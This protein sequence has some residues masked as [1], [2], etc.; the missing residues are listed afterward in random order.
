MVLVLFGGS[1]AAEA[2]NGL[3][4]LLLAVLLQVSTAFAESLGLA[5]RLLLLARLADLGRLQNGVHGL[6]PDHLVGVVH[7]G[8]EG[9]H[10]LGMLGS[11][12][13]AGEVF[14]GRLFL[15]D[16][17]LGGLGLGRSLDRRIGRL[18]GIRYA[19]H[20]PDRGRLGH[21]RRLDENAI[22]QHDGQARHACADAQ[23]A[24]C[25]ADMAKPGWRSHSVAVSVTDAASSRQSVCP[26]EQRL[27]PILFRLE[28]SVT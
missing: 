6:I 12:S 20:A 22:R 8:H 16:L 4:D 28:T 14:E 19:E 21:G 23:G 15:V 2:F 7:G 25:L 11:A 27:D 5:N 1:L 18:L 9:R 3:A 26:A 10:D 17:M 13:D 24:K